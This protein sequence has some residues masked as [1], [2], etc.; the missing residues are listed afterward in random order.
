MA[1]D[2]HDDA[3]ERFSAFVAGRWPTLVRAARLLGCSAHEA[4][5]LAQASLV[6]V[7]VGW[8]KVERADNPD[9]YVYKI[10]LNTHASA[11]RKRSS[12]ERPTHEL[13]AEADVS[14]SDA[15]ATGRAA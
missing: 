5:D 1:R 7:Y 4:E 2:R 9:S 8:S 6:K 12:G 10:L 11:L 3:D 14:D 15:A 13:P